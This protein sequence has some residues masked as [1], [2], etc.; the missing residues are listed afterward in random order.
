[1]VQEAAKAAINNGDLTGILFLMGITQ[2][3]ID[4]TGL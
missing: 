3:E 4:S 2:E 1:M